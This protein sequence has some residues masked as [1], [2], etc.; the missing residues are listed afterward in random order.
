MTVLPKDH[1]SDEPESRLPAGP[2]RELWRRLRQ[3]RLALFSLG[4]LLALYLSSAFAGFLAPCHFSTQH[5]E[6]SWHPPQLDDVHLF[7]AEGSLRGPFVY[8]TSRPDIFAPYA[9]TAEVVPLDFFVRGDAYT[10]LGLDCTLHL[11]GRRDG[12]PLFLLGADQ[13]GRDV[14]SRVLYGGRISLSVGLLGIAISMSLGL[15]VGGIA[16]Y[17]GGA[18]DFVLMRLVELLLAL[19]GLYLILAVRQ[20]F[21]Q[22]LSSTDTYL[23][24]VVVLACI[25]WAGTA[26]VIRGMVLSIKTRDFVVAA[27]ALGLSR[28][29]VVVRHILPNTFSFVIVTATLAVP[30]YILGEV[31]LSFLGMGI[32]EPEASWGNMLR[33][34]QNV[35]ALTDYPW[36]VVPGF[37][38]FA[39]VMAFNFLGDGLRDAADPRARVGRMPRRRPKPPRPARTST[40]RTSTANTTSDTATTAAAETRP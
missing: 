25:G 19:P 35:R 14:L 2:W 13:Y 26:R 6:Q 34:A 1:G 24:V 7:D 31:S 18:V 3:N 8:A 23:I 33:D 9:E 21:G 40:A 28:L 4:V 36:V 32:Q 30:Y 17:F 29:R 38:I 5:R 39:A 12:K 10:F 15:L 20:A 37:F 11:V 16:G 22:G 27:E